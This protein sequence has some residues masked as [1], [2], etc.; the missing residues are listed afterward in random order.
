MVRNGFE[1]SVISLFNDQGD[2]IRT[3]LSDGSIW[4]PIDP[5]ALVRLWRDK[6][7]PLD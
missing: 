2:L 6:N 1:V 4:E 7:L 5:K 3:E